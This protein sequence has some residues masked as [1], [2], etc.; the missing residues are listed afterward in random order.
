MGPSG[1][2]K[3]TT[4]R[5]IVGLEEPSEGE[6]YIEQRDMLGIPIHKRQ[7]SMVFQ[8]YALFPHL[9]VE[10]NIA[11]GLKMQKLPAAMIRSKVT[12]S[13]VLVRLA[14]L[15]GIEGRY[16]H[17]LSGGQRQRVALARSLV[18]EPKVL[19]LDEPFGAL[20]KKLRES[21]QVELR[22]L[23]RELKITMIFVTHDQE[24]ALTLSDRIAVMRDGHVEQMGTPTEVYETP[25]SAF[26]AD[27]I[28][29][30]NFLRGCVEMVQDGHLLV[31]TDQG[32]TIR[33]ARG[34]RPSGVQGR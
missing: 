20:D 13:L 33:V 8:D 3:T 15:P 19:L 30:S 11:F 32:L 21:M 16:P 9:T 23:Q 18:T 10:E 12:K 31:V 7:V 17:Q 2:G 26:V 14:E 1:C 5:S 6:I 4:L 29:I 25:R 22:L 27:F 28:G 34:H 24:E